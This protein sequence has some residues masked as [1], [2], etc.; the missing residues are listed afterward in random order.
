[1]KLDLKDRK[2]IS[3]LVANSKQTTSQISKKTRIPITTVHNRIKRLEKQGLIINY[4]VNLDYHELGRPVCAYIGITIN[5]NIP[6]KKINQIEVANKIK[7]IEGVYETYIMTGGSDIFIKI[8]AKDIQDLNIIVTERLRNIV[9][10]D[11]TQTAI[12]LKQV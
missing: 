9:G 1:M 12:V 3:E 7:E 10:V 11:K 5:Y 4:T 8:L 6:N 2:I